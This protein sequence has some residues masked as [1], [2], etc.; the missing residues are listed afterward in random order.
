MFPRHVAFQPEPTFPAGGMM[1][2]EEPVKQENSSFPWN[3]LPYWKDVLLVIGIAA[4]VAGIA[5]AVFAGA[6]PCAICLAICAVVLIFGLY[7]IHKAVI[8]SRLHNALRRVTEAHRQLTATNQ[9][10]QETHT[11]LQQDHAA[12][13]ETCGEL[14]RTHAELEATN[15]GLQTTNERL[16]ER[17]ATLTLTLQQLNQTADRIQQEVLRLQQENTHMEGHVGSF[18]ACLHTLDQELELSHTLCTEI[19]TQLQDQQHTFSEQLLGLQ[20]LIADLRSNDSTNEKLRQLLLLQE[21]IEGSTARLHQIETQYAEQLAELAAVKRDLEAIK[22]G[23]DD[24]LDSLQE[25]IGDLRG[26][27]E[28]LA[29]QREAIEGLFE[30]FFVLEPPSLLPEGTP[31]SSLRKARMNALGSE[32]SR[33]FFYLPHKPL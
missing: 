9:G 31:A 6:I 27:K 28:A 26:E 3:V 21:Q 14:R 15:V 2:Q 23:F 7:H 12:L 8:W 33:N 30:R 18:E 25:N 17:V 20:R 19:Q 29:R 4:A 10:L 32:S 24:Q 13:Q 22:A 11:A 1:G 16:A 5:I